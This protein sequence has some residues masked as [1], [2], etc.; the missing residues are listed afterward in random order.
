[1]KGGDYWQVGGEF[2]FENGQVTWCHR[3][4]NTRDHAALSDLR[5]KLGLDEELPP[6]RTKSWGKGLTRSLSNRR[7]SWSRSRS[8]TKDNTKDS[9]M[10]EV[11]EEKEEKEESI[12][13]VKGDPVVGNEIAT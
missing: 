12:A 6:S 3:M 11:K 10:E 2:L 4:K 9:S 7:Q 1:M 13:P 8:R 5:K